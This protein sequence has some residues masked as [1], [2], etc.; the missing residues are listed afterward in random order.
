M[1]VPQFQ[2]RLLVTFWSVVSVVPLERVALGYQVPGETE[3]HCIPFAQYRVS[4]GHLRHSIQYAHSIVS[5]QP[6]TRHQD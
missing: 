4:V 6:G 5:S 1:T 2:V 3:S